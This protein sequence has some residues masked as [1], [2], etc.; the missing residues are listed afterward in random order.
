M[1]PQY[2]SYPRRIIPQGVPPSEINATKLIHGGAVVLTA[3]G[4]SNGSGGP[5]G[6]GEILPFSSE[7][8]CPVYCNSPDTRS[9]P[10]G[11]TAAGS[12]GDTTPVGAGG[13][14]PIPGGV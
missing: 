10:G 11:G 4:R 8:H 6:G 9:V 5:R 3:S 2:R 1:T 12:K 7:H 14:R 13:F